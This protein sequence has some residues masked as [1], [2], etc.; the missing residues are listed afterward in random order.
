MNTEGNKK[1]ETEL[2]IKLKAEAD[3]STKSFDPVIKII[4]LGDYESENENVVLENVG[5]RDDSSR[6]ELYTAQ[7]ITLTV[8]AVGANS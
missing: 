7:T 5:F 1:S 4:A 6:T 2:R 3:A 8:G